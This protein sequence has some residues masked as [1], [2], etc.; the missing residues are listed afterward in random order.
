MRSSVM[1]LLIS[2]LFLPNFSKTK[3]IEVNFLDSIG[4]KNNGI[5]PLMVKYDKGRNRTILVNTNSSS[6]SLINGSS[7]KVTNIPIEGRIPQYLKEESFTVN[8]SN[9][10]IYLIGFKSLS[11][12]FPDTKSSVTL[13]TKKQ[14]DMVAVDSF[15]GNCFLVGRES[16]KVAFLNLKKRKFHFIKIF[17][18]TEKMVNLNQTPPPP[19]RKIVTDPKL[20]SV[21]VFDGYTSSLITLNIKNGKIIKKRSL[22]I[23]EGDRFHFAG[24]NEKEHNLYLVTET[25]QRKVIQALKIDCKKKNDIFIDLPSLSEGVGINYCPK[26]DEIYIPYDNHPIVHIVDFKNKEGSVKKVII[27]SYGNDA[28]AVNSKKNELYV[29]S[30]AFG[31]I[32]I[33]DLK[34]Q[35]LKKRIKNVGILPHMFS[36]ALNPKN[37][38]L[39]IPLG[40]TAV[41]GSFGSALTVLNTENFN[42]VKI[43]TGWAPLD[44]IEIEEKDSFLVFNTEDEFAEVTSEGKIKFHKLPFAYPTSLIKSGKGNIFLSYG[45]HQSYWPLVYIWG[46]KNGILEIDKK[47]FQ[48]FDRRVPRLAQKILVDKRGGLYGLQ[49]SWGKEKL[50]LTYFPK[51]LRLFSPQQRIY[52]YTSIQR[53]NIQRILK[54]DNDQDKIYLVKTGEKDTENGNL[55]II[56]AKDNRLIANISTGL[57]PTDLVFNKTH[58]FIS[59]F[60]SNSITKIDKKTLQTEN[61]KTEKE[62]LKIILHKGY[63]YSLNHGSSSIRRIGKTVEFFEIPDDMFPDNMTLIDNKIFITAHNDNEFRF[64]ELDIKTGKIE[65]ILKFSYPYGDTSFNNSNTA[66]Y[67]RGQFGDSIYEISQIKSGKN[68]KIWVTDLLSGRLFIIE[69]NK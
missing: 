11:I 56:N 52:F 17:D 5:G 31:E 51:G 27:P 68:G 63:L 36:L 7:N 65:E 46:A 64:F 37:N 22:N 58:I 29:A 67:L 4:I 15:T 44:L 1:F 32:Y 35:V 13:N 14:Y 53:E 9:G 42:K 41:N 60:D 33:I 10:N 50:F 47:T 69:K 43:R 2:L 16:K 23:K 19:I 55:M 3:I 45:P 57:T 38:K 34:N 6:V 49:N 61:I 24:Y 8:N 54:Y 48:I 66:F 18:R 26:R 25:A 21:F 39:Y 40:A 20:N 12:V 59:N 62:P 30:W 28:S